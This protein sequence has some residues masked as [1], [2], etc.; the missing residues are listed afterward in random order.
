[1]DKS[2]NFLLNL[3]FP[4][5][6]LGCKKEG[7]YLC[8]DCRAL[9]DI[10]EFN[11]CLCEANGLPKRFISSDNY[12]LSMKCQNCQNKILSGLYFA[13]SYKEKSLARKLIHQFKYEPYLKDLAETLASIIIE[14]FVLTNK[15][16]NEFWE[17]GILIPVPL[18]NKKIR[19]RGYNQSE[20]LAKELSK[21]LQVPV[22]NNVLIKTQTTESQ[23]SL[24]KEQRAKNL[25]GAFKIKNATILNGKKVFLIDDVYTTGSTMQECARVLRDAGA[26]SIWGIALAREG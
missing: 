13:L 24:S 8:D 11:Y 12:Q 25:Q 15:N 14:H 6:C 22:F 2:K 21:T 18:D 26:K 17:N 1:V 3:F 20:E 7:I 23:I 5:F 10:S 19:L 9:L 16:K 4:K